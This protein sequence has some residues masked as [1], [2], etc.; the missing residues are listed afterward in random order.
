MLPIGPCPTKPRTP[1]PPGFPVCRLTRQAALSRPGDLSAVL[2]RLARRQGGNI[3]VEL[4]HVSQL[5]KFER[6]MQASYDCA[7]EKD[8]SETVNHGI[9]WPNSLLS[10]HL[11]TK[12]SR[13]GFEVVLPGYQR[14]NLEVD[15]QQ[16]TR[17]FSPNLSPGDRTGQQS[18]DSV[19]GNVDFG[20][21]DSL[22]NKLNKFDGRLTIDKGFGLAD[23][24]L[25]K[26]APKHR[27]RGKPHQEIDSAETSTVYSSYSRI[28]DGQT[29]PEEEVTNKN[30]SS[31]KDKE[32][33]RRRAKPQTSKAAF[34]QSAVEKT[35]LSR[36]DRHQRV[37]ARERQSKA[38]AKLEAEGQK[39]LNDQAYADLLKAMI[40]QDDVNSEVLK[41]LN[42][43]DRDLFLKVFRLRY[44]GAELME[45]PFKIKNFSS[46]N[47]KCHA[48]LCNERKLLGE[49]WPQIIDQMKR[50]KD[51]WKN[52]KDEETVDLFKE[53]HQKLFEDKIKEKI[54]PTTLKEL[55]GQSDILLTNLF[56]EV[57]L[58]CRPYASNNQGFGLQTRSRT[59]TIRPR[60]QTFSSRLCSRVLSSEKILTMWWMS[61]A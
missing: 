19:D 55:E 10:G 4:V 57:I 45:F 46:F 16:G 54:D 6:S 7:S 33:V 3:F 53:Y 36:S 15:R 59:Y 28:F 56:A 23:T 39:S 20:N 49:I 41:R 50:M 30:Q 24:N 13:Y 61:T 52:D 11:V 29:T 38:V 1:G 18:E 14:K 32:A 48:R 60:C 51:I 9:Y 42:R 58:N 37:L 17:T 21:L 5:L 8:T 44:K 27:G 26:R 43:T 2:A 47:T 22:F 40:Y 25:T 12:C 35:Q 34:S 31:N